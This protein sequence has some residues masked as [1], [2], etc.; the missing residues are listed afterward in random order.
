MHDSIKRRDLVRIIEG[1]MRELTR[2]IERCRAMRDQ[3]AS[4]RESR[5]NTASKPAMAG[6]KAATGVK[7]P[8]I[9]TEQR[10][11]SGR[12]PARTRL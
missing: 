9:A 10:P 7:T 12:K 2:L 11:V 1:R 3:P 8:R 4:L 5:A 6:K